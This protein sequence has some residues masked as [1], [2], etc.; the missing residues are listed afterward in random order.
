MLINESE[1]IIIFFLFQKRNCHNVMFPKI[2]VQRGVPTVVSSFYAKK[3][4]INFGYVIT[5]T[6]MFIYKV[7]IERFYVLSYSVKPWYYKLQ[8]VKL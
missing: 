8:H 1:K 5:R 7:F 2:G 6:L 3:M 4:A